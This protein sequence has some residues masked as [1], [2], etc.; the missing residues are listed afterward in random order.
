M[1]IMAFNQ[2]NYYGY[3]QYNQPNFSPNPYMNNAYN[4]YQPSS[5]VSQP[6]V[7][8][9]TL[10][11]SQPIN[12]TPML[13]GKVVDGIDVVKAMDVPINQA[14]I[15]PKADLSCVYIKS[16]NVDGTT[17]VSEYKLITE[18]TAKPVTDLNTI[19]GDIKLSI[20][21]LDKKFD[22]IRNVNTNQ[23]NQVKKKRPE[24][25]QNE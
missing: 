22:R 14:A 3:G 15:C 25:D 13:Y 5:V 9:A 11:P 21:T 20:D 24:D 2:P 1:F 8:P 7:P 23:Q 4:N 19:L 16:W 6:I 17:R 12:Q 10:P 18:E